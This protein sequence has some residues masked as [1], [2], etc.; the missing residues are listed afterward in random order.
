MNMLCRKRQARMDKTC[1]LSTLNG[2]QISAMKGGVVVKGCLHL[3]CYLSP[4]YLQE[5]ASSFAYECL[6]EP[7]KSSLFYRRELIEL[8]RLASLGSLSLY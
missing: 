6:T 3:C 2:R 4:K 7:I 5:A 8:A 1:F